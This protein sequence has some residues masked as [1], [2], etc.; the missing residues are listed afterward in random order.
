MNTPHNI[1][2]TAADILRIAV[3]QGE[4]LAEW[5]ECYGDDGDV[6]YRRAQ[7]ALQLGYWQID[8]YGDASLTSLGERLLAA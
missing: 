1:P 4:N 5:C 2:T 7:Q 3:R 8:A 6:I